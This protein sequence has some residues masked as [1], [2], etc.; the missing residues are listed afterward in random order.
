MTRRFFWNDGGP[1]YGESHSRMYV[2]DG[3]VVLE[4][5]GWDS[6]DQRRY[7]YSI[8]IPVADYRR[9]WRELRQEGG[10]GA[11]TGEDGGELRLGRKGDRVEMV[12]YGTP[13]PANTPGGSSLSG[14]VNIGWYFEQMVLT[15][16]ELA[17]PS[18]PVGVIFAGLAGLMSG[19]FNTQDVQTLVSSSSSEQIAE[20]VA[21][22]E[23]VEQLRK[24]AA[25]VE[26][27]K[28]IEA[29]QIDIAHSEESPSDSLL[30]YYDRNV[31]VVTQGIQDTARRIG[32]IKSVL[33]DMYRSRVSDPGQ[34]IVEEHHMKIY[35]QSGIVE[36]V[37]TFM[38]VGDCCWRSGRR[39]FR[40]RRSGDTFVWDLVDFEDNMVELTGSV[41][42]EHDQCFGDHVAEFTRTCEGWLSAHTDVLRQNISA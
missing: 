1:E 20:L 3:L 31:R 16:D 30:T 17:D 15:E 14:A 24:A 18:E 38:G 32:A 28:W 12:L 6:E 7:D 29:K 23:D 13:D 5:E 11:L 2:E 42:D 37:V 39:V 33:W 26:A 8:R 25:Q 19:Q 40:V 10:G 35:C 4:Y 41:D 36:A 34:L 9:V 27:D 21:L 22:L